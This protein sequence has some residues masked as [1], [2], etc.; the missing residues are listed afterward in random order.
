MINELNKNGKY[1]QIK[2]SQPRL[3]I[4]SGGDVNWC[5]PVVTRL[6]KTSAFF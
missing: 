5:V 2:H 6:V 4:I 3:F 1:K